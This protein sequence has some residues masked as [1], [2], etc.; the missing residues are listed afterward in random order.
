[1]IS[2]SEKYY[3]A[4]K[5]RPQGGSLVVSLPADAVK[6]LDI[7]EGDRLPVYGSAEFLSL[8]APEHEVTD[9]E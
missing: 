7:S 6:D 8:V 1:M 2:M 5:V 9:G 3:G 4:V